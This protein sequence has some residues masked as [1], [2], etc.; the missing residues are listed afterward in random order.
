MLSKK[1]KRRLL[2]GPL[3]GNFPYTGLHDFYYST[4]GWF[5]KDYALS[6]AFK[7]I[8]KLRISTRSTFEAFLKWN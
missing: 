3:T 2:R 6:A 7:K 5:G 8:E 1:T 4:V